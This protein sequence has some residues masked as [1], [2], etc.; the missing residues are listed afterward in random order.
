MGYRVQEQVK[1]KKE[2]RKE[3][4]GEK[5]EK[6]RKSAAV[7][8]ESSIES[9]ICGVKTDQP[10]VESDVRISGSKT[11]D[12]Q[13]DRNTALAIVI[14]AEEWWQILTKCSSYVAW[15]SVRTKQKM[16]SL[17]TTIT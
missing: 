9:R 14:L 16:H 15:V 4:E 17:H 6:I 7:H 2:K 11:D 12:D 8:V 1:I 10:S 5:K 13:D 3:E